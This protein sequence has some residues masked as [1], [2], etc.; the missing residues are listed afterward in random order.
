[1]KSSHLNKFK[2]ISLETFFFHFPI[3]SILTLLLDIVIVIISLQVSLYLRLGEDISQVSTSA[4]VLNTTLYVLFGIAVFLGKHL[5]KGR[6]LYPSLGELVP[7]SLSVTY[8]T[9]LYLPVMYILP[10][11]L[12]LPQSTPFIN[13]FVLIILLWIPRLVYRI[14]HK[15]QGVEPES[16]T[17]SLKPQ[18]KTIGIEDLLRRPPVSFDLKSIKAMITGKRILVTGAG[19][20]IGGELVRKISDFDPSHIC[21]LDHS[22]YLLY[23]A[24]LELNESYPKLPRES[25]LGDV[26]CRE[27]IRHIISTFKPEL[28]FHAAALKHIPLGEENPSQAVFTNVLGTR[29]IAEACRDFNVKAMLLISSNEATHPTNTIGATKRLA[30]CYCQALDI[31][32]RKKPNGTRYASVRFG[33]VIGSSGSVVPLFIRQ[34]E[35]GGPVTITHPDITRYFITLHEAV[36]LILQAMTFTVNGEI[37]AGRVFILNMGEP[38][39]IL[40]LARQMIR[41]TGFEPDIDIEIK[42]TGLRPGE[43]L[44]EEFSSEHLSPTQNPNIFMGAPRTM[45]HGFLARALQ[46]LETVAKDQDRNSIIRLLQALVP[47]YTH[48]E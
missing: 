29:N 41:L 18:A 7:L 25:I 35:K 22:E 9:L 27:R 21:L 48:R 13:W 10:Q 16:P 6:G 19:G 23:M 44:I 5:Y 37:P 38:I 45:D 30:E 15:P 4:I 20:T 28:V 46:E 36:Q 42:F 32:E 39:K 14:V 3:Q 47:D 1:M 11:D 31:L 12:S 34:I 40:D 17:P 26:A 24:D 2:N 43:K 33:N 8:I